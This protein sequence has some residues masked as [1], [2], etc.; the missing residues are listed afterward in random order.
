MRIAPASVVLALCLLASSA[1]GQAPPQPSTPAPA[2]PP[3]AG[4][5]ALTP[6]G[7]VVG[8]VLSPE[9]AIGIALERILGPLPGPFR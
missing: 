6:A 5:E 4:T 8:R 2:S 7:R 1:A 3:P 9:E